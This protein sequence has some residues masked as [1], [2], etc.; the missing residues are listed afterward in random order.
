MTNTEDVSE[1][2]DHIAL[3]GGETPLLLRKPFVIG[4]VVAFFAT[5]LLYVVATQ[6]WGL[7]FKIDAE[8]LRDWVKARGALGVIVFI[9]FMAISVL[10]A[11]I[12]N[13]PIFIAAGL[14][15]GPILGT[16]YC[17]IGLTIGSA[18]AFFVARKFGR[19]HLPKLIG[20]S[21]AARLDSVVDNFG[22]KV[23][24]W[25]RLMPGVNFDWISFVAGMTSVPFRT[26][27][28]YSFLG[29]IPPTAVTVA[30]GDGL[31]RNPAITLALGGFWVVSILATAAYFW[32]RRKHWRGALSKPSDSGVNPEAELG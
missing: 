27:I 29:M 14:A 19:K 13:V 23:V 4:L 12:P 2:L 25:T 10:F 1:G 28:V 17:M 5:V 20:H 32:F 11:P 22:G 26:F 30:M 31:T 3:G 24:F 9:L 21:A 8:P 6:F 18:A 15:W 16:V 7:S